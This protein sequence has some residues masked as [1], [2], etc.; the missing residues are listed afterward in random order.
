MPY[1]QCEHTVFTCGSTK[2]NKHRFV[3]LC[4]TRTCWKWKREFFFYRGSKVNF[5]FISALCVC[6]CTLYKFHVCIWHNF[7]IPRDSF[8]VNRKMIFSTRKS[9][10]PT[11]TD[12]DYQNLV[13]VCSSVIVFSLFL[14]AT[15]CM[16]KCNVTFE[17]F[18]DEIGFIFVQ[19][20]RFHFIAADPP[21]ESV[22]PS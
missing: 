9:C 12:G 5:V 17:S 7:Q 21:K 16:W 13:W 2:I 11:I 15:V 20:K 22:L 19:I 18:R 6:V 8:I 10:S 3:K 4:K 14:K 1:L